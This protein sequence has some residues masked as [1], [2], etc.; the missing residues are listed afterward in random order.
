MNR[1]LLAVALA[2]IS[3][4]LAHAQV[5]AR[6]ENPAWIGEPDPE[7]FRRNYPNAAVVQQVEGSATIECLVR[8]DTTVSCFVVVE[9]PAGW[10]F[11]AAALEIARTFRVRPARRDGRDVEGGR[12]R[13]TIRF[14]QPPIEDDP[15]AEWPEEIQAMLRLTPPPELPSWD[16][17]PTSSEMLNAYPAE[18]HRNLIEGRAN[19][20]CTVRDDRRLNCE[21]VLERPTGNGFGDAATGVIERFRV[22]ETSADFI[23][24][25]RTEPFLLPVSFS[26]FEEVLPLNRFFSGMQPLTFSSQQ[27]P[28]ELLPPN[29][30]ES[31]LSVLCTLGQTSG[32]SCTV[33]RAT[34]AGAGIGEEL[35]G[36]MEQMP[37]TAGEGLVAGD[38]FRFEVLFSPA[39]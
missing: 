26:R 8:L 37:F 38:Q 4:P 35:I 17:A 15:Y 34:G 19:F 9:R 31:S 21:Q 24:R 12:V 25:H 36:Q 5:A 18:A 1:T 2:L 7:A 6:I 30:S 22:S 10:G 20:S 3:A 11:G 28:P 14:I 27:L 13:R 23:A 33:E 29:A 32:P 39:P 16:D